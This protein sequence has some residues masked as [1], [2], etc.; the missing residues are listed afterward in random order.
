M[1]ES[2]ARRHTAGLS[3]IFG[4]VVALSGHCASGWHGRHVSGLAATRDESR[5]VPTSHSP[6]SVYGQ[7]E[8]VRAG[9]SRQSARPSSGWKVPAVQAVHMTPATSGCLLPAGHASHAP[10]PTDGLK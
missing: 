8:V 6:H 5:T 10:E 1:C 7:I 4:S 9:H 3:S 2:G